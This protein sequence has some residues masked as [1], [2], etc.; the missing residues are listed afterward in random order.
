[1]IPSAFV[2]KWAASKGA[3][4]ATAQEHFIDLCRLLN[5]QTPNEADPNGDFYAFEK[6]AKKVDGDGFADVWLKGHFA[7][8]YKGKHKDLQAAYKQVQTYREALGNPPLLVVCDIEHFEIHT[9]WTNTE[10]W[11]YRFRNADIMSDARVEVSTVS[12]PAEDAPA[13]NALQVLKALFED[14]Q[15][16]KPQKTTD[17]IT[18]DAARMF[19]KI[20]D[21]LRKWKVDDMRIARLVTRVMFCMFATDVGLLPRETFSEIIAVHRKSGD[22]KAFRKHLS[23]LFAVMNTGGPLWLY[24][25][26]YF[27]GRL[28]EDNDVPEE[29]TTQEILVLG[30]LDAL[31]WADVEPSIFGTLFE[32][33]L[34]PKQRKMLG[35]HYTS[36]ADIELIVEPV[37]MA[38]LRREW[39]EVK[40]A[41]EAYL[42]E[43]KE[44]GT[45]EETQQKH[46]R[47]LLGGF[48]KRLTTIRIL[49]PA[50]GSGNFL[51][52]SL[53]LLKALE[54][55]A[56]AFASLHGVDGITSR[57]HP[58]QL[59]GIEISPYAVELASIVIWIGYLQWKHRN[60]M[61]LDDEEPILEPLDQVRLM[62]A[63]LDRSDANSPEEPLWPQVD[64]VVG[65]PPFLGGKRLRRELGDEYVDR[66]FAVWDGRVARE[67]DLCCYW[68]E[69]GRA[70][71]ESGR[72]KRVGLLAT[73][74]I[75]GGANR[76]VLQRIK[77]TGDIFY[78]QADRK[79]IQDGVA[80]RVSM[81]G[82]DDG[83]ETRRLLNESKDD[84]AEHALARA[85]PVEGINA[86]LTHQADVTKARRLKQNLGISFMGDTKVGPFDIPESLARQFLARP[87]PHGK[88]NSDVVRPWVNGLD[89]TRR[90][91][92]MWIIDFPPGMSERDAALYEAPFEYVKEHVKPKRLENK[93]KTYAAK[94]WVHAE[95]RP[96]MRGALPGLKRYLLT[97]RVTK[98]RFFVWAATEVLAD[99]AV[100]AFAR[101]DDYFFGVLHSRVHEVWAR[102]TGT[103]LREAE[104]G[105]RY[106]PTTCFETFPFPQP[107]PQQEEAIAAAAKRLN[108]L[109]EE[110]LNPGPVEGLQLPETELKKRTLTNLYNQRPTWLVNAHAALDAAVF[111]AYGWSGQLDDSQILARLLELNLQREPA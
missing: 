1:M 73:Q 79:W 110:W 11:I 105:F 23:E 55:E 59:Y 96:E 111:D 92:R 63:I 90:P 103:Q 44:R 46:L 87:N 40:A 99:S 76:R 78:A 39:E 93:R 30:E 61:P 88:P 86:N 97:P 34:D 41:A 75:R 7:W 37:L 68:H 43:A 60:V 70:A 98:Y 67:S 33:V 47:S 109:R 64:V 35:A 49:D 72:A 31:N 27:D 24:E 69:K 16:L 2:Q 12:G 104:S 71:I 20:S 4:R 74:A 45:K 28:F 48:H 3:E 95:P 91:R 26:P 36:R 38:P 19:G 101:S 84:A 81:V 21:E 14:P 50:C 17:Q 6:G 77:E 102:G 52:V 83:S 22:D 15:R 65:N 5:E 62:D 10:K 89:I 29:V 53:A 54:K 106:T 107:T 66:L 57:V 80:V 51:Y 94:W 56:I 108:R 13:L 8:E 82:F 85:R 18:Q 100:I 32:R 42:N 58:R 25:I 9:N